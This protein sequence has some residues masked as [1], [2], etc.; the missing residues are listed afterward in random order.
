MGRTA[1]E[2]WRADRAAAKA[3]GPKEFAKWE[4]DQALKKAL[5]KTTP[6]QAIKNFCLNCVETRAAITNCT[7]PKCP[8]YIYRP[9]QKGEVD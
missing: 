6:M 5:K 8:L 1:L 7:A 2:E 9:Y 4:A 3:K